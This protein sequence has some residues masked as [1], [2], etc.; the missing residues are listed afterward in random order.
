MTFRWPRG[1]GVLLEKDSFRLGYKCWLSARDHVIGISY[2]S[3][4]HHSHVGSQYFFLQVEVCSNMEGLVLLNHR[5]LKSVWVTSCEACMSRRLEGECIMLYNL[6]FA[7]C[8]CF[9]SDLP[10]LKSPLASATWTF[11]WVTHPYILSLGILHWLFPYSTLHFFPYFLYL[12][13]NFSIICHCFRR[14]IG[15]LS[16]MFMAL[17]LLSHNLQVWWF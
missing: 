8:L 5:L 11:W 2:F 9:S 7:P 1:W 4:S 13:L 3:K 6:R 12:L 14:Y 15:S 16:C 17:F 10:F